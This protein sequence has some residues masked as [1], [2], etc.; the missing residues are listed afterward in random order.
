[1]GITHLEQALNDAC[2]P[3]RK[4]GTKDPDIYVD[5]TLILSSGI[6]MVKPDGCPFFN[7]SV[8][9]RIPLKF[10]E[11]KDI[12]PMIQHYWKFHEKPKTAPI[13]VTP[14]PG[15]GRAAQEKILT[16]TFTGYDELSI[17]VHVPI[18]IEK[19]KYFGSTALMHDPL[20]MYCPARETAYKLDPNDPIDQRIIQYWGKNRKEGH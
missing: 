12:Q 17:P 11:L 20:L 5:G 13:K 16:A 3:F 15:R 8:E 2:I 18:K 14:Q 7:T 6:A 19:E 10:L 1:M 9:S 4:V